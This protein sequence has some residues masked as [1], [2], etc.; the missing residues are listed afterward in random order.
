[1][2]HVYLEQALQA[3]RTSLKPESRV[4]AVLEK[5]VEQLQ[6]EKQQLEAHLTRTEAW[7]EHLGQ[8]RAVVQSAEVEM[9]LLTQAYGILMFMHLPSWNSF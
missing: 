7:G 2:T 8:W 9:Q 1:V 6:G 3:L 4:L 5:E